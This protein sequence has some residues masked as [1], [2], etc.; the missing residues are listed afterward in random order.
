MLVE[1]VVKVTG[2]EELAVAAIVNAGLVSATAD[3][4]AKVMV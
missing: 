4:E 3:K 1:A 2:K